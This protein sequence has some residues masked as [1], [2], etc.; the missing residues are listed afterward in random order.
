MPFVSDLFYKLQPLDLLAL[1]SMMAPPAVVFVSPSCDAK[2]SVLL[3]RI[4]SINLNATNWTGN[5][6][7]TGSRRQ[8][9]WCSGF[10]HGPLS[11]NA[12]GRDGQESQPCRS[13]VC[14]NCRHSN[15]FSISEGSANWTVL[16]VTLGLKSTP[17]ICAQ[18]PQNY[19]LHNKQ[20]HVLE[21]S[22]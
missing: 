5:I 6:F 3:F 13:S 19:C 22:R 8:L 1:T 9:H 10:L 7:L 16:K 21:S 14:T 18:C 20:Y 17:L 12:T 2:F 4:I 15:I 11:H